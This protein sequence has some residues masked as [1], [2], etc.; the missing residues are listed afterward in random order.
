[1]ETMRSN[2]GFLEWTPGTTMCLFTCGWM[3]A[4]TWSWL[5]A[6]R[7]VM[8]FLMEETV[9]TAQVVLDVLFI[10]P[11]FFMSNL[12]RSFHRVLDKHNRAVVL[13]VPNW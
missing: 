1:M 12:D 3:H 10:V 13:R 11:D 2:P 7:M 9:D 6:Y 5:S 8:S 4:L